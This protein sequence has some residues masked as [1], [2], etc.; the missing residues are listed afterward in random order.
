MKL[1]AAAIRLSATDL[2]NYLACFHVTTLDLQVAR[3]KS[4]GSA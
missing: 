4:L 3:G 2:S 1:N